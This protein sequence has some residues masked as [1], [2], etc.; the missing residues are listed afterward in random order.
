[1]D[2]NSERLEHPH[3]SDYAQGSQDAQDARLSRLTSVNAL[4]AAPARVTASSMFK[5]ELPRAMFL[6]LAASV[7]PP[8]P[9]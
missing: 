7:P 8:A 5:S 2:Q 9:F 4:P 1:M 6:E 3:H